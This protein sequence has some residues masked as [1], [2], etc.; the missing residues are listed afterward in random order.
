M[1]FISC[2]EVGSRIAGYTLNGQ[3]VAA[4]QVP[5]DA[6][7]ASHVELLVWLSRTPDFW[8]DFAESATFRVWSA[9]R[10][11]EVTVAAVPEVLTPIDR[12]ELLGAY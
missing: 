10:V 8:G 1:N 4:D 3:P 7:W 12:D 9:G 2:D 6:I 11:A 5:A